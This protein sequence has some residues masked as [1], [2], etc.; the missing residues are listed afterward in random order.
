MPFNF[1]DDICIA[2]VV[3]NHLDKMKEICVTGCV[4]SEWTP[5]GACSQT[6]GA[7]LQHRYR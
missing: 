7:G 1:T 6:C 4:Y 3:K 5:W 2:N